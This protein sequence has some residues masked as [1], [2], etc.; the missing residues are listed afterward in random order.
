M[1]PAGGCTD[2]HLG[3]STYVLVHGAWGGAHGWRKVRRLLQHAGHQVY[4]PCL[5]GQGERVHLASRDVDLSTHI[6]DVANAIW[7]EDLTDIVLVGHSYGGMVVTG[8]ADKLPERIRHLVFLDAFQPTDGQSLYDIARGPS[9]STAADADWRVVPPVRNEDANNP[10]VLWAKPRRHPQS[11]ATFDE[12]VKL[13]RPLEDQPFT[14][15]YIVASERPDP[16]PFF[17]QTAERLRGS[18]RWTVRQVAGGHSMQITHPRELADLLL[19]L[20]G[21]KVAASAGA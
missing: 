8:V 1:K 6:Q 4:T 13:S 3:M 18:P 17:D 2:Y 14:L 9:N 21:S 16:S 15:T 12:K 20:F 10:D 7:Y 11:R 5:T 19:E